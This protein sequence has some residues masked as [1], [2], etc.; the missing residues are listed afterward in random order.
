[1]LVLT[2]SD[3]A[4]VEVDVVLEAI[5]AMLEMLMFGDASR[6]MMHQRE[7]SSN[8]NVSG[9][10]TFAHS[11][12]CSMHSM[13]TGALLTAA[14]SSSAG[15]PCRGRSHMEVKQSSGKLI[16]ICHV[17]Y[18]ASGSAAVLTRHV[19]IHIHHI[20]NVLTACTSQPPA[21]SRGPP[22]YD[23]PI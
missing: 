22:P 17:H 8:A 21:A 13:L 9:V 3:R 12:V 14:C 6:C 5:C 20:R 18:E 7:A 16:F 15:D 2:S 10:A 23:V 11:Q 19:H 4:F 1:M